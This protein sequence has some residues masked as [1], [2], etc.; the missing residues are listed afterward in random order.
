M[1]ISLLFKYEKKRKKKKK[2]RRNKTEKKKEERRE[3]NITYNN[4]P[5]QPTS[6]GMI[7]VGSASYVATLKEIFPEIKFDLSKFKAKP[8]M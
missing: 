1:M 3:A 4:L 5:L 6:A 7:K 8:C 2:R